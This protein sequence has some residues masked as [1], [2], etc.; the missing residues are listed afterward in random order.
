MTNSANQVSD[1]ARLMTLESKLV[2]LSDALCDTTAL[3]ARHTVSDNTERT[4]LACRVEEL[5]S[6]VKS[7]EDHHS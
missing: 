5:E 3:V 7:L 2:Q 6:Q 1:H 4:E